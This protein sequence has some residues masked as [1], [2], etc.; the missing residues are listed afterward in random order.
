MVA[1][2]ANHFQNLVKPCF[3][4]V[5]LLL[6]SFASSGV[7]FSDTLQDCHWQIRMAGKGQ[8]SDTKLFN[9]LFFILKSG[10]KI[11]LADYQNKTLFLNPLHPNTSMHILH[12]VLNIF[13]RCWQGEFVKQ[14]RAP[15]IVDHFSYSCDLNEWFWGD[16]VR[17]N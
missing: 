8:Y 2:E 7:I 6:T 4:S 15:F 5:V 16:I 17:R 12:T 14:S 10:L 11:L 3:W 13:L 1:L 9:F